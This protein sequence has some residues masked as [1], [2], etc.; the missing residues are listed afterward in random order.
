MRKVNDIEKVLKVLP[1][2][3]FTRFAQLNYEDGIRDA[4][5]W[6]LASRGEIPGPAMVYYAILALGQPEEVPTEE[7]D[8]S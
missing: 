5:N 1:G 8:A 2:A 3:N 6:V 4:F 7:D